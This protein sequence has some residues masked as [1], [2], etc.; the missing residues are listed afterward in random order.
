[1]W[2]MH[3]K[4]VPVTRFAV[5]CKCR[6]ICVRVNCVERTILT[7]RDVVLMCEYLKWHSHAK[8]LSQPRLLASE[9]HVSKTRVASLLMGPGDQLPLQR[10]SA[11]AYKCLGP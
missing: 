8:S 11:L 3:E 10:S 5:H 7:V 1:M 6:Y 9:C 4:L 2:T